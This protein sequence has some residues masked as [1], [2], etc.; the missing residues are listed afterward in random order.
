MSADKL[1]IEDCGP[2][3]RILRH[4]RELS[5]LTTVS[6][7]LSKKNDSII[8]SLNSITTDIR[9]IKE[10][11]K[12]ISGLKEGLSEANIIMQDLITNIK[13]IKEDFTVNEERIKL[14]EDSTSHLGWL[15]KGIKTAIDNFATLL[16]SGL[17]VIYF[18][19]LDIISKVLSIFR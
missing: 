3:D 19:H 7:D 17:L 10:N 8:G 14:L 12:E 9:V 4:E 15:N 1:H 11:L 13:D 16:I 18:S 2:T 5:H 6:D